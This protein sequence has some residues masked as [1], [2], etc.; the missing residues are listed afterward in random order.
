[1]MRGSFA[2]KLRVLRARHGL[3]LSEA[4]ERVG[5]TRDTLSELERGK[6]D[7]YTPTITKLARGYGLSVEELLFEE[8]PPKALAR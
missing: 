7:P 4:A 1:M 6:R 5:V 2:E 8:A 3:S